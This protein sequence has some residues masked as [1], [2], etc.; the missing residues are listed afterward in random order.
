MARYRDEQ[1][2]IDTEAILEMISE[3]KEIVMSNINDLRADQKKKRSIEL[4][5]EFTPR[6]ETSSIVVATSITSKISPLNFKALNEAVE[7]LS[8]EDIDPETG[9]ILHE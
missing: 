3:Q 6:P 2:S 5:I 1:F 8:I 9:E 4:K 7:Q